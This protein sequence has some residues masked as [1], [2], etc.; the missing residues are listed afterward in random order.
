MLFEN[1]T[2]QPLGAALLSDM[3]ERLRGCP[4]AFIPNV[5]TRGVDFRENR[6]GQFFQFPTA[7]S[8]GDAPHEGA[9]SP[10]I[11]VMQGE[12]RGELT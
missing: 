8:G 4:H 12:P 10:L 3:E 7:S 5:L 9:A 11:L 1:S 6:K 2:G